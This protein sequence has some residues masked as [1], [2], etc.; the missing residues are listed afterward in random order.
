VSSTVWSAFFV[1]RDSDAYIRLAT[2]ET[3]P[4]DIPGN[5]FTK[6]G[7][8]NSLRKYSHLSTLAEPKPSLLPEVSLSG[9]MIWG[10]YAGT[11]SVVEGDVAPPS[12]V[13]GAT[14]PP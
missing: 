12:I 11:I 6:F 4:K 1:S 2:V 8:T 5:A 10:K 7:R 9:E 3:W 14:T 13:A